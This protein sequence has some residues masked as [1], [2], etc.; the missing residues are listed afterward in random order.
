M[1]NATQ[2]KELCEQI[3][4]Y[5]FSAM[6]FGPSLGEPFLDPALDEDI[7]GGGLRHLGPEP[8]LERG[9]PS[10]GHDDRG[11]GSQFASI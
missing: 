7:R 3:K 9:E 6:T 1:A 5:V 2:N 10:Q 11:H 4:M 8:R